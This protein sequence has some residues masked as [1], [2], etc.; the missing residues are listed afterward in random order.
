MI[1]WYRSIVERK[2][3]EGMANVMLVLV[4]LKNDLQGQRKVKLAEAIQFAQQNRM[5]Y[6]EVSAKNDMNCEMPFFFSALAG[7]GD[8][9]KDM[10][11]ECMTRFWNYQE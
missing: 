6:I 10:M 9:P 3:H 11:A 5:A 4:G 1:Q 8:L 7:I 2:E